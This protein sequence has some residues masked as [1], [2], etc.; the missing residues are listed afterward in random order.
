MRSA[1]NNTTLNSETTED[2]DLDD[3]MKFRIG[4]NSVN[5]ITRQLLLTID[6]NATPNVD[7]A[8]DGL[9]NEN[10]M[11]DMFWV[12]NDQ[13]YIIQASN[14]AEITTT[15]PLG[16]KSSSDGINS[17][18]IDALENIPDAI[19]IYLH[20]ITLDVYHDLRSSAYEIF[21]N[22]G[23]YLDRFEITFDAQEHN[24]G[25]DDQIANQID[26]LY[27]SA[28]DK[29]VIVNP[30]QIELK[31]MTLFN[32]L[33]Q[34]IYTINTIEQS[35]YSEYEIHNLSAGTY[36]IKLQTASDSFVTKKIIMK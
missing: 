10:Q 34:S 24:L 9:L 26:V 25:V 16:I 36:I 8:Y 14:E 27:S 13:Y 33:G 22:E 29:V 11:D 17:I 32:M 2:D 7:W 28:I 19:N 30:N 31:S 12:I 18:M 15:Y 6:E 1:F 23:E 35:D 5:T 20:D 21:L 3:R 4:F